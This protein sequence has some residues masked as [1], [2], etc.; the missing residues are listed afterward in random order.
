[1]FVCIESYVL[2]DDVVGEDVTKPT[3]LAAL[4]NPNVFTFQPGVELPRAESEIIAPPP[5]PPGALAF[6]QVDVNLSLHR[7]SL[8]IPEMA[9]YTE[10][11][12]HFADSVFE[13]TEGTHRIR[14]V[15]ISNNGEFAGVADIV[16]DQRGQP[17]SQI[18]GGRGTP[19]GHIN[20]FDIFADGDASS[21]LNF[22]AH[23][24]NWIKTCYFLAQ[25]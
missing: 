1:M 24:T 25:R 11:F 22:L 3:V 14:T 18:V 16:W 6:R 20:M 13:A 2:P 15:T 10:I 9:Q 8:S 7:S 5:F 19:G 12:E 17:S 21:D 23:E 4:R